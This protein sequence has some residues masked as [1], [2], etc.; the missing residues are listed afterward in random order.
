[1]H[2]FNRE[3]A[4]QLRKIST[5]LVE[6][7]ANPFRSRAYANAADTIENLPQSV[8]LLVEDKGID[9]LIDLPTI[10]TGIA[11]SIYEYVAV[12]RMSRLESLQGV[13]DPVA[14]FQSIP[15]VGK[16][17]AHRI[18]DS[19]QVDTLESLENAT[20]QGHLEKVEGLGRKRQEAIKAWLS[21]HLGRYWTRP[22]IKTQPANQP[23]IEIL[24]QVDTEYRKK[25][26]AG[27]L[28]KITPGRFNPEHKNW[29]P[30]LH[31][32]HND[33]HFTAFY[34]NTERAHKLNRVHD[35]VVIFFYDGDHI[36]GQH[37]VVTE[38]QGTLLGKRVVRGRELECRA[39]Y[40]SS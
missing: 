11:R 20:H 36:E 15:T 16:T 9:G 26:V 1:M 17:L 30:I 8:D 39:F 29:L 23:S 4:E 21:K 12:G 5:L 7:N 25:S 32:S 33:W 2:A 27:K 10:G 18:Y 38:T 22:G 14:L 40:G 3:V 28:P 6:Q 31:V 19:L 37:T 13:S 24:L 34:S 35:W